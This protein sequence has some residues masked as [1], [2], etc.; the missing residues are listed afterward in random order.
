MLNEA[1]NYY[2]LT[3]SSITEG[4]KSAQDLKDELVKSVG[5]SKGEALGLDYNRSREL[6]VIM[7]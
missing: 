4:S 1:E 7:K 6:A 5:K 2:G 3:L